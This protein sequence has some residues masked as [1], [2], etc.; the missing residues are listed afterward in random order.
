MYKGE[1]ILK[2]CRIVDMQHK[3]VINIKDGSC[4]GCVNDIEIDT[5]CAKLVAIVVYGRLKCFGLLGRHD[6]IIIK[7]DDIEVIGEDT[8]LVFYNS[9]CKPRRRNKFFNGLFR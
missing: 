1:I 3:D 2:K 5:S 4:L 9:F 6:D 7:W 8:I